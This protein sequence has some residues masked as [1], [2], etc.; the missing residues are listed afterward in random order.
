ML[1]LSWASIR[2]V[3]ESCTALAVPAESP[4]ACSRAA[5]TRLAAPAYSSGVRS[6]TVSGSGMICL[7]LAV[8]SKVWEQFKTSRGRLGNVIGSRAVGGILSESRHGRLR[9]R[10]SIFAASPGVSTGEYLYRGNQPG[11][12]LGLRRSAH[13]QL[14]HQSTGGAVVVTPDTFERGGVC[15]VDW[16]EP[17]R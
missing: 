1:P 4:R 13:R 6:V 3:S 16:Q 17:F 2:A 9:G 12:S 7:V 5:A 10:P 14:L 15:V 8:S 11:F